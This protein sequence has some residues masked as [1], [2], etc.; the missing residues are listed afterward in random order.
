MVEAFKHDIIIHTDHASATSIARQTTL[1]TTNTD[2]LNLR[3]VRASQYLSQFSLDVRHKP[4]KQHII[5]EALSRLYRAEASTTDEPLKDICAMNTILAIDPEWKARL[6]AAYATDPVYI[7]I[8][9]LVKQRND[10]ETELA[11]DNAAPLDAPSF[12]EQATVLPRSPRG[13]QFDV[14]DDGLLYRI[15]FEG[16]RRLCI[17]ASLQKDIFTQIHDPTHA[18]F[19]RSYSKI[20]DT[21]YIHVRIV[22]G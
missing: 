1:S 3:L 18:G 22:Q 16:R 4:G 19:H 7:E 13:I 15:E 21:I 8:Q 5:P 10:R 11:Q 12:R 9:R 14:G 2:K 6:L 17:P 20:A